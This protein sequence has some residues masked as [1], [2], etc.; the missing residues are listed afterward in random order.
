MRKFSLRM[1]PALPRAEMDLLAIVKEQGDKTL[2]KKSLLQSILDNLPFNILVFDA[3]GLIGYVNVNFCN[4]VGYEKEEVLGL[5]IKEFAE[6]FVPTMPYDFTRLPRIL[7]GEVITGYHYQL[8]H[9][10]GTIIPV[11]F[12]SYPLRTDP[13]EQPIGC[14]VIIN[15]K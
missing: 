6:Y 2:P 11:E 13:E 15:K 8:T 5:T 1:E 12:N 3:Q 14:L 9:F 10:D 7:Q 4:L